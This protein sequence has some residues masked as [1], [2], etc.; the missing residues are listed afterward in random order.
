[1]K[2]IWSEEN[3]F[4]KMT[5]LSIDYLLYLTKDEN[6]DAIQVLV[7]NIDR[8][9]FVEE[10]QEEEK[11]T[12]HET[13]AFLNT[14]SKYISPYEHYLHYGL[15]SS[16]LLDTVFSMQLKCALLEIESQL[17]R[18]FNEL[19]TKALEYKDVL[20]VG[21]T[22][23]M[24]AECTTVG[25]K[26]LS[27]AMEIGRSLDRVYSAMRHCSV[28]KLSGPVGNYTV[29]N[30]EIEKIVLEAQ[31][32][33]PEVVSTQIIPRDRY[34]EVFTTLAILASSIERIATEIRN[35][36]RS[37][38]G[39][40][41]EG[42]SAGS[43]SMP[44]KENPVGSE[45]LCGLARIIRGYVIPAL[46]NVVLWHERDMSHSS[47]ERIIAQD[48]TSLV[49]YMVT[50]LR[51]IIENLVINNE[52]VEENIKRANGVEYSHALLCLLVRK[53]LN[54]ENAQKILSN[55]AEHS[56]KSGI[57]F[58]NLCKVNDDLLRIIT[59]EE[60]DQILLQDIF[61]KNV[62]IIFKRAGVN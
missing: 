48:A 1:M 39:E 31:N 43:S 53:N 2:S 40:F 18:L 19:K 51:E 9:K 61:R 11:V 13:V 45:N 25:L 62:N 41:H 36:S 60:I 4:R 57:N 5:F 7:N 54:K 37:D 21:R 29:C 30:P 35:H 27:W 59:V 28:G 56:R 50:R 17:S 33:F 12:R 26:F 8:K 16:D 47:A 49:Y 20:I 58:I 24:Y 42:K 22:H 14:L 46:E 44:H 55:I 32:L 38:I 15:T 10:F 52:R 34:A 3:R 23:G 6:R